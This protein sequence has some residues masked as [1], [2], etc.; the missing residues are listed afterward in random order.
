[1]NSSIRLP[2]SLAA[3][4]VVACSAAWAGTE[5][6][7]AAP[8]SLQSLIQRALV[9]APRQQLADDNVELA[10]IQRD[11]MR[12][13]LLPQIG[14]EVSQT[15]QTINMA[16]SGFNFPGLP[17]LVGPYNVFDARLKLSQKVLDLARSSEIA[18]AGYAIDAAQAQADVNGEQIA[19][20]VALSY[21]QV[22]AGEQ[23]LASAQSDMA[24]ADDLLTLARDQKTAGIASGVDVARAETALAQDRY[25]VSEAQTR[26]AQARLQLQRLAVLP[27]EGAP[28]LA[29]RLDGEPGAT[30]GLV[31]EL[32][33][34]VEQ[35]LNTARAS[36]SELR[37]SEAAMRQA[38]AQ[39]KAAH[40]RRLPTLSLVADYGLSANTPGE[41]QEDTYRYGAVID[42]PI[43]SGG[44]LRAEDAAAANRIEQQRLQMEDLQQQIEQDVRLALVTLANSV[45]QL[46]AAVSARD[47]AQRELDLARDRF[48]N[49]VANNVDVVSAQASLARSRTQYVAAAAAEQQARVNLA[50]AQG[51]ARQF[52][53]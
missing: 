28:L 47:L 15:R 17:T 3:V 39:L 7:S 32:G 25:A 46:R 18:G 1:M 4:I 49:G 37:A 19:S 42:L 2:A 14:A 48:T 31:P 41:N 50:A 13:A 38:D 40:R 33:V 11:S 52:D 24:L 27:M 45:E 51:R 8:L 12:A 20:N 9:Q 36:R 6:L 35:A 23:V 21:I 5:P 29:G 43:Y 16:A 34:T 44:S 22:L 53:L 30:P 26:I 10:R